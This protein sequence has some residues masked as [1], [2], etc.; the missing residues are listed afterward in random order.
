[1]LNGIFIYF[2][3]Y[4]RAL[5]YSIYTPPDLDT[6]VVVYEGSQNIII[7]VLD[8]HCYFRTAYLL[9]SLFIPSWKSKLPSGIIFLLPEGHL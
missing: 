4:A 3:D 8:S 7:I 2:Q 9:S 1:M 6:I 5:E